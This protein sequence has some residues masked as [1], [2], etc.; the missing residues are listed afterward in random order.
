MSTWDAARIASRRQLPK[1]RKMH[2]PVGPAALLRPADGHNW[3]D[4]IREV[5]DS[6]DYPS[7]VNIARACKGCGVH[8]CSCKPVE[9]LTP[10]KLMR[11]ECVSCTNT[12]EPGWNYC[13]D[14]IK[15]RSDELMLRGRRIVAREG[16][17]NDEAFVY[18]DRI[19]VSTKTK[20]S[21]RREID[22][23]HRLQQAPYTE[24]PK[25]R[26]PVERKK[27]M[28]PVMVGVETGQVATSTCFSLSDPADTRPGSVDVA[29]LEKLRSEWQK[30][31]AQQ[32]ASDD[33]AR[34]LGE[35]IAV[36]DRLGICGL[37]HS[38]DHATQACQEMA[39]GF[40]R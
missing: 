5:G 6:P 30:D 2:G 36:A 27:Y 28:F 20:D 25:H 18:D 39:R 32:T 16:V 22:E 26:E 24:T 7:R 11:R 10:G 12:V 29:G 13:D 15:R 23:Q 38:Y 9:R 14:C 21:L 40:Y 3:T 17:S 1:P 31:R 19:E 35:H 8:V 4:A 37:C 34:H 33:Y